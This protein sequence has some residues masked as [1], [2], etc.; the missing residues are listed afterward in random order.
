M[1]GAVN[2]PLI[3]I[4]ER[5]IVPIGGDRI[6]LQGESLHLPKKLATFEPRLSDGGGHLR[7][8]H[9]LFHLA[10]K[11]QFDPVPNALQSKGDTRPEPRANQ[12]I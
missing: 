1:K 11:T 6:D 5:G 10:K 8:E 7:R 2:R 9:A 12:E 4:E 3:R